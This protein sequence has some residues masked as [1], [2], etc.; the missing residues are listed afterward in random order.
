MIRCKFVRTEC[1]RGVA[2]RAPRHRP[3][4]LAGNEPAPRARAS[5]QDRALCALF[6]WLAIALL[7]PSP[8]AAQQGE[9]GASIDLS[10]FSLQ[11]SF[12]YLTTATPNTATTTSV[13]AARRAFTSETAI[14]YS[15]TDWYQLSVAVPTSLTSGTGNLFDRAGTQASWNG[16]V[17]RQLFITPNADKRDVYFGVSAQFA[18]TPP[19]AAF[20][21][22]VDRT[23]F[24]AGVT[25]IV[26]FHYSG[27]ELVVSSTI[28]A[29]I[30]TGAV[31][32]LAAAARLTRKITESVD[33]GIEYNAGLGQINAIAPTVQQSHI[34]YAVTDFTLAGSNVS[35]GIGYGLTPASNGLA[36]KIGFSRGF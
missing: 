1:R 6:V 23:P 20:P 29:G 18:Y 3:D 33:V 31:T 26:G 10:R 15:A 9:T 2:D 13:P 19:G 34:V 32:S 11:Q 22:L 27:Y 36:A 24:S 21:A 35:L 28:A 14:T 7:W 16:V 4:M 17:V 8:S 30:G 12:G 5:A 25:P